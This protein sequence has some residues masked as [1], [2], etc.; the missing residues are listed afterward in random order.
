MSSDTLDTGPNPNYGRHALK[1]AAS[2]LQKAKARVMTPVGDR[3]GIYAFEMHGWGQHFY[4]VARTTKPMRYQG[5][6][7]VSSQ[8]AILAHCRR[9]GIPLLMAI[10][11]GPRGHESMSSPD[12]RLFH[13]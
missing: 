10:T 3:A 9:D 2:L 5:S 4:L 6:L 11:S 7:I 1:R 8:K 13:P 12:W